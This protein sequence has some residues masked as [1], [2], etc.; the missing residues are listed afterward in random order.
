MKIGHHKSSILR[1][2]Y[3]VLIFSLIYFSQ[4]HPYVHFHHSHDGDLLPFEV[5]FHPIDVDPE[6]NCRHDGDDHHHHYTFDQNIDWYLI[7]SVRSS[8]QTTATVYEYAC[9]QSYGIAGFDFDVIIFQRTHDKTIV[10]EPWLSTI[11][12]PRAPPS[13]S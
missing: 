5:S 4:V 12:S 2:V 1:A 3:F 7:R 8:V 6:R 10:S 11:S 9:E 13:I